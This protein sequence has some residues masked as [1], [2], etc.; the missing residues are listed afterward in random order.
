MGMR[1]RAARVGSLTCLVLWIGTP[2]YALACPPPWP[3]G[4]LYSGEWLCQLYSLLF[5]LLAGYRRWR[6]N[7]RLPQESTWSIQAAGVMM[8]CFALH[9]LLP[10]FA[11]VEFGLTPSQTSLMDILKF[12]PGFAFLYLFA[13]LV[14]SPTLQRHFSARIILVLAAW[15][16]MNGIAATIVATVLEGPEPVSIWMP[17]W[18]LWWLRDFGELPALLCLLLLIVAE[19]RALLEVI[20]IK[21]VVKPQ[22]D[23]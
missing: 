19:T 21:V 8:A 16:T 1:S 20:A 14:P 11:L 2:A 3:R 13:R 23:E 7:S 17:N 18:V 5:L 9:Q 15:H 10:V 12:W 22:C 4:Y 6:P